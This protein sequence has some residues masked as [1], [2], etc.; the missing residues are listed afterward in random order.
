MD[1]SD[2]KIKIYEKLEIMFVS[3]RQGLLSEEVEK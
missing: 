2:F 1:P 3:K